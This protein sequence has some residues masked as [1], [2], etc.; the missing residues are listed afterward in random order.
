MIFQA[1]YYYQATETNIKLGVIIFISRV[2]ACLLIY[3]LI[4]GEGSGLLTTGILAGSFLFSGIVSLGYVL[5]S[6]GFKKSYFKFNEIMEELKNGFA[7]FVG[8]FSVSLFRGSNILILSFVSNPLAVS[9]YSIA[10]KIVKSLQALSRPLNELA[11]P[12]IVKAIHNA[13][14]QSEASKIIWNNTKYQILIM[15]ALIPMFV[16]VLYLILHF[17]IWDKLDSHIVNLINI[18]VFAILFGIANFM[19]GSVGLNTLGFHRY[20]ALAISAAGGISFLTSVTL[21][22]L[23]SDVGAS[24]SFV[25]GEVLLF[26][27][28]YSK[29]RRIGRVSI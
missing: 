23:F 24:V 21:S 15:S 10:E 13:E 11:F 18:M 19:Y 1:N 4:K 6:L 3:F 22:Y 2:S 25:L 26:I 17:N 28:F 8:N 14:Q 20:Y 9:V 16:G 27:F 5:F 7:I 12:K 29:Y